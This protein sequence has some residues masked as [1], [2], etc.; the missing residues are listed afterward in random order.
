M[1][2][3]G[4]TLDFWRVES[5]EPNR[6]LRLRAEMKVPGRAWLE[7]EVCKGAE[8]G[9]STIRQT[10]EF[11]PVGLSGLCYWYALFPI[12]QIVFGGMLRRIAK[13][14]LK[15]ERESDTEKVQEQEAVLR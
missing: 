3:V 9:T 4:D 10:A 11:D 15:I 7:F 12:H 5:I 1:W 8:D 13:A 6:L 14:A 2:A